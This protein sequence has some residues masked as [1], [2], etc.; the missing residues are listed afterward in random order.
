VPW[1][2]GFFLHRYDRAHDGFFATGLLVV[3]FLAHSTQNG[4]LRTLIHRTELLFGPVCD[5]ASTLH[6][7]L[8]AI[9]HVASLAG[10]SV[11]AT[12]SRLF[13][14]FL[15]SRVLAQFA[16]GPV[17]NAKASL[18]H[19]VFASRNRA[20]SSN[21]LARSTS[22]EL[23]LRSS[24]RRLFWRRFNLFLKLCS[25]VSCSRRSSRFLQI[26]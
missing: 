22:H 11:R 26:P 10:R 16:L 13:H 8:V 18:N 14:V 12:Q 1:F 6:G 7:N 19:S 24:R 2:L 15:A 9:V 4:L 23:A 20:L 25:T 17:R 3:V 21:A 5:T